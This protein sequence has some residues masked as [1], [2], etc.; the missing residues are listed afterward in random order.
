VA[1]VVSRIVLYD[2]PEGVVAEEE[3]A[4]ETGG[5]V[6]IPV[7]LGADVC[8][9]TVVVKGAEPDVASIVRAGAFVA[10]AWPGN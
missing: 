3:G 8:L 5:A 2:A 1:A 4:L 9:P 7:V 10:V 6:A